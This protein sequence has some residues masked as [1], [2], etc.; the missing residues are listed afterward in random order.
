MNRGYTFLRRNAHIKRE[1]EEKEGEQGG[2]GEKGEY[3]K[4]NTNK[5][6]TATVL[7]DSTSLSA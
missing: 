6:Q 2:E 5:E 7:L 4:E 1:D 3:T